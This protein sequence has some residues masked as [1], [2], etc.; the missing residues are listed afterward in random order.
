MTCYKC[1]SGWC[2]EHRPTP[3]QTGLRTLIVGYLDCGDPAYI[4]KDDCPTCLVRAEQLVE[5]IRTLLIEKVVPEVRYSEDSD[6]AGYMNRN[7]G[8]NN[9]RTEVM[10]KVSEL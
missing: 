10:K 2:Q 4:C 7:S 1:E 6:G 8:W 5:A 3:T 9:A